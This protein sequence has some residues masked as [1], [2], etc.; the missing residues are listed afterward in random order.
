MPKKEKYIPLHHFVAVYFVSL[1]WQVSVNLGA[2]HIPQ[3]GGKNAHGDPELAQRVRN[4]LVCCSFSEHA[5]TRLSN[6]TILQAVM[7]AR[8]SA[9]VHMQIRSARELQQ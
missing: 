4:V 8:P 5:S 3:P 2:L 6:T 9:H 1:W 7:S